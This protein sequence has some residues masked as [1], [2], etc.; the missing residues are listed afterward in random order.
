[1]LNDGIRALPLSYVCLRNQS[2]WRESNPAFVR[3]VARI[4][5]AVSAKDRRLT[6]GTAVAVVGIEPTRA[7]VWAAAVPCTDCGGN[8]WSR[9]N[10]HPVNNRP[11]SLMSFA[12]KRC[13]CVATPAWSGPRLRTLLGSS[14][15]RARSRLVTPGRPARRSDTRGSMSRLKSAPDRSWARVPFEFINDPA[16]RASRRDRT[17]DL[18]LTRRLLLAAELGRLD[19]DRSGSAS[20]EC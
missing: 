2:Q 11:L 19:F 7:R 13:R 10:F 18:S 4:Q 8:G 20:A 3:A 9:T 12:P 5:G 16:V 15:E 6:G 14:P 17:D 1:M